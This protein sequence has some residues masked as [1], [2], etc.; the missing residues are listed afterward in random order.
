MVYNY[1]MNAGSHLNILSIF[2]NYE[3]VNAFPDYNDDIK[4]VVIIY[5]IN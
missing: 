5:K 3:E 4:N 1:I 2:I